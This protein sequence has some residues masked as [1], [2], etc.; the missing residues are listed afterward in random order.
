MGNY[1][2]FG[3]VRLCVCVSVS[4]SVRQPPFSAGKIGRGAII[5]SMVGYGPQISTIEFGVNQCI[6]EVAG[7]KEGQESDLSIK[8][9]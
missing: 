2:V 5:G 6:F 9:K 8:L 3:S 1:R 7:C 4:V